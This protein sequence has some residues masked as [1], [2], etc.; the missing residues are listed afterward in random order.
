VGRVALPRTGGRDSRHILLELCVAGVRPAFCISAARY[1]PGNNDVEVA[2][3]L[4]RALGLDHVVPQPPRRLEA[5]LQKNLAT[6]FCADEHGWLMPLA[7]YL[8]GRSLSIYDGVAGDVPS[9]S[10]FK[11]AGPARAVPCGTAR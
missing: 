3:T 10:L 4:A 7:E 8:N 1:G 6:S 9:A 11:K 2:S 5:E